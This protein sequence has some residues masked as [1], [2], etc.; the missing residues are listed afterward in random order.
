[1]AGAAMFLPSLSKGRDDWRQLLSTAASLYVNGASPD[2]TA[3]DREYRRHRIA[4]PTYPFERE[5]YW[6][7]IEE[8]S[9]RTAP[10]AGA[11][12]RAT[13]HPLLGRRLRSASKDI[14]F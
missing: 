4:L 12:D 11:A 6:L 10:Q 7:P 5:R 8:G 1:P 13:R 3:F 14:Q 9:G 2:W